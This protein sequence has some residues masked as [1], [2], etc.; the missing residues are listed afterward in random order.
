[1]RSGLLAAEAILGIASLVGREMAFGATPILQM[2]LEEL[3]TG[4]AATIE[5]GG[6]VSLAPTA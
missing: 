4:M 6:R 5:S 3:E 1:M 2:P